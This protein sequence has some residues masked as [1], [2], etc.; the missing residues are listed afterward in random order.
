MAS[1]FSALK[2]SRPGVWRRSSLLFSCIILGSVLYMGSEYN[3][4]KYSWTF[5]FVNFEQEFPSQTYYVLR[6][7]EQSTY[8]S[9]I[10]EKM[11]LELLSLFFWTR[12]SE[13][14]VLYVVR[15]TEQSTGIWCGWSTSFAEFCHAERRTRVKEARGGQILLNTKKHSGSI[16]FDAAWSSYFKCIFQCNGKG[17]LEF[18]AFLI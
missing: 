2:G 6:S 4:L 1:Y 11:L 10:P 9:E 18:D 13:S 16:N 8:D 17:R 12:I 5:C 7:A 15:S 14:N 3:Y